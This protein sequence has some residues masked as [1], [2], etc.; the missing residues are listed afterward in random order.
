MFVNSDLPHNLRPA[1]TRIVGRFINRI[2]VQKNRIRDRS[3]GRF[4][5]QVLLGLA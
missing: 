1:R 3:L 4:R 5:H 2:G